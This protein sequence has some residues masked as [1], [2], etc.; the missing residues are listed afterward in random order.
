MVVL[1]PVHFLPNQF[2]LLQEKK[3][4]CHMNVQSLGLGTSLE[5]KINRVVSVV[6]PFK[7]V[8]LGKF[9]FTAS[10]DFL[11]FFFNLGTM[12]MLVYFGTWL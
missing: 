12:P 11:F 9:S 7:M 3:K 1:S 5:Q 10:G 4:Y 6:S 8:K 2:Q